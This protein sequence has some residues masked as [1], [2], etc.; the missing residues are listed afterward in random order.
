M[1]I[2]LL[3]AAK[4]LYEAIR[5]NLTTRRSAWCCTVFLGT[6]LAGA[7]NA[8]AHFTPTPTPMPTPQASPSP[9]PSLERQFLKNI[10]RDQRAIWTSPFRLKEDD[11]KWL[12]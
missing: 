12:V 11:A 7:S 2:P 6:L 3:M 10:L 1:R 8:T 5:R 4:S 9:T